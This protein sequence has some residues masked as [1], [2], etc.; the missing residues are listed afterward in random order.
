MA[1]IVVIR[2]VARVL[3]AD[4]LHGVAREET[5][6]VEAVAISVAAEVAPCYGVS[7]GKDTEGLTV[8]D[9]STHG[10]CEGAIAMTVS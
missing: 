6:Q 3:R 2:H 1:F 7:D 8:S 5:H 10:V 4:V 9:A